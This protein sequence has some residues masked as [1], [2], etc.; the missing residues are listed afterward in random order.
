MEEKLINYHFFKQHAR[1]AKLLGFRK[2][3]NYF[4]SLSYNS[5]V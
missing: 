4:N 2:V 5:L 3:E 1:V